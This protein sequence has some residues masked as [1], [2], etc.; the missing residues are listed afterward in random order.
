MKSGSKPLDDSGNYRGIALCSLF[1]KIFDW[2]FLVLCEKELKND[3]NQFGFQASSST[4]MATWTAIEVIN[5]F[6]RQGAS[7]YACLL[8]Y[9]KAFDLVNHVKMFKNLMNRSMPLILL[10]LMIY[11][12][13]AQKCYIKWENTQSYSF[14]VTNGVR[15]GSIFS[16]KGGFATYLD[17]LIE[18][19]RNSGYGCILSGFWF[20]AL[21]YAD[22]GILLSTSVT[23]L[24][25]MVSICE[26]HAKENDLEFST[27]PDP[28]KSKT[29][30]MAFHGGP[31]P[32]KVCDIVLNG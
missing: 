6:T 2:V 14:S 30:C 3:D 31:R 11:M 15:Q 28:K 17:P 21:F 13:L 26:D 23:G 5:W 9:R 7:I 12:Y 10:R 18:E 20:G 32:A 19:L 24:Q 22:D 27:D 25:K 29:V 1:L 4:V 8:D 16:P